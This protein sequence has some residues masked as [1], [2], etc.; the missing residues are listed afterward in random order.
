MK[1]KLYAKKYSFFASGNHKNSYFK[2]KKKTL[3]DNHHTAKIKK[4][5]V[6][7]FMHCEF[8]RYA[9]IERNVLISNSIFSEKK[10][11]ITIKK[12]TSSLTQRYY[13]I[14]LL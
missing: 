11:Y 10:S 9:A 12:K 4:S 7:I 3:K 1:T 6:I 2:W 8:E 5:K 13:P 14:N